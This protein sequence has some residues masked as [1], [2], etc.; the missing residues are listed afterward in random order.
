MSVA[1][2]AADSPLDPWL[3]R[4]SVREYHRQAVACS[5]ARAIEETLRLPVAPDRVVRALLLM[6]GLG[7]GR[8]TI[9]EFAGR[10]GFV[11]LERTATSFVFGLAGRIAGGAGPKRASTREEW[12]SWRAPGVKIVADFRAWPGEG[13]Q[14]SVLATETRVQGLDRTSRALFRAYWLVVGPFS[15]LIRRRWL[16]A[17]ASRVSS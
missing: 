17:V 15:A 9:G 12:M 2:P 13:G 14:G 4:F 8:E 3:P 5:P 1:Q 6:R 11:V 10:G 16:R 7:A